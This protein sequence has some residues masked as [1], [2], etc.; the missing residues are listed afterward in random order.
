MNY[1]N[2]RIVAGTGVTG[3]D[4]RRFV[5]AAGAVVSGDWNP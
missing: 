2:A 5:T 4:Y 3:N 1:E